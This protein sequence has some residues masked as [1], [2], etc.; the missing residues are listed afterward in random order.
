MTTPETSHPADQPRDR[1]DQ[2]R[3]SI[4][5]IDKIIVGL[6]RERTVLTLAIAA[7]KAARGQSTMVPGRHSQVVENYL[8]A[9]EDD[10]VLT[11]EG[12]VDLANVVMGISR[13]AQDRYRESLAD[14]QLTE[15]QELVDLAEQAATITSGSQP[16]QQTAQ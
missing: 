13:G 16:A 1:I 6:V 12:V 9:A 4:D 2:V 15:R 14:Q 8:A 10:G 3:E 5:G 7:E 11:R